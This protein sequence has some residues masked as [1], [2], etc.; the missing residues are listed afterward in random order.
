MVLTSGVGRGQS[1]A[2]LANSPVNSQGDSTYQGKD[3][4]D[5]QAS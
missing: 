5:C 4:Q 3:P 2:R 1:Q